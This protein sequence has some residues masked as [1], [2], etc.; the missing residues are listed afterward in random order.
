MPSIFNG[1]K[2]RGGG[3]W[4]NLLAQIPVPTALTNEPIPKSLSDMLFGT[5]AERVAIQHPTNSL[6]NKDRTHFGNIDEVKVS[7]TNSVKLKGRLYHPRVEDKQD[8]R[9]NLCVLYCSGSGGSAENYGEDVAKYY[10]SQGVK[11]LAVNYRGFGRSSGS[12]DESGLYDDAYAMYKF[13]KDEKG[14]AHG[15]I[16]VHGYSLGG[17]IAASL[18]KTLAKNGKLVRALVLHSPMVTSYEAAADLSGEA[19]DG[20][21]ATVTKA[22]L[23]KFDTRDKLQTLRVQAANMPIRLISG[24]HTAGDQ[25]DIDAHLCNPQNATSFLQDVQA[26]GFNNLAFVRHDSNHAALTGHMTAANN[27]L[28]TIF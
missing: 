5:D 25:L 16:I 20:L 17:P 10:L 8:P 27:I 2:S 23:G 15:D 26:M 11:F 3:K 9:K 28:Q 18:A 6:M 14:I 13:L 1:P 4:K 12:P 7:S 21:A 22:F 19:I 24:R